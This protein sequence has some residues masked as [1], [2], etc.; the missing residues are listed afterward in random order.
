MPSQLYLQWGRKQMFVLCGYSFSCRSKS[1]LL[2]LHWRMV[3]RFSHSFPMWGVFQR[4]LWLWFWCLSLGLLQCRNRKESQRCRHRYPEQIHYFTTR[5][6]YYCDY[7]SWF[8]EHLHEQ[9]LLGLVPFKSLIHSNEKRQH[10]LGFPGYGSHSRSKGI[11]E[12]YSPS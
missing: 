5:K 7:F 1:P 4:R 6:L 9:Y 11:L 12:S 2:P 8:L 10:L 3:Y